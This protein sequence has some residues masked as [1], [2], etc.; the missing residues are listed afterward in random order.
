MSL[1][2]PT[3]VAFRALSEATAD[4]WRAM[5]TAERDWRQAGG[6]GAGLLAILD[7]IAHA[8]ALRAPVNLYTHSLQTATRV[9]EA[10]ED[11]ELVV[12]ALFHD[13]P[14]AFSA[15][16]HGLVAA[17]MLAPRLSAARHWLLV[18]HV[19]FQ[20]YHYVQHPS[21]DRNER[22]QYRGHP[23]FEETAR[24]CARYDQVSFDPDF[25]HLPLRDF[26]P[27]VRRYF[28]AAAAPATAS[29]PTP[30]PGA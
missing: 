7:G 18:H 21:R 20:A 12:V 10:G 16:H 27:I 15:N 24:F 3:S 6:P 4:D 29:A 8:D 13:L 11:D 14:E 23:C 2:A 9:V 28:S 22:E 30:A 5:D 17:H 25:V 19:E 26:A 1:T